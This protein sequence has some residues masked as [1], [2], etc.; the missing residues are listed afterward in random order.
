MILEERNAVDL[1]RLVMR[2][3]VLPVLLPGVVCRSPYDL[4]V[5]GIFVRRDEELAIVER[6]DIL[7][8][9]PSRCDNFPSAG[10]I[11][12]RQITDLVH[13]RGPGIYEE[14]LL[15]AGAT[16]ARSEEYVFL[17]IH[18]LVGRG[19]S[20]RMT[21]DLV[22]ALR[23]RIFLGIE[24]EFPVRGPLDRR[25]PLDLVREKLPR[26]QVFDLESVLPITVRIGRECEKVSVIAWLKSSDSEILLGHF[27]YQEAPQSELESIT[28]DGRIKLRK[29]AAKKYKEMVAAARAKG[30]RLVPISGFRSVAEQKHLFF[31]VKAER[32]QDARE[33][34]EVSAP[35]GHSEHHTGYAFDIGDGNVPATNLRQ[36]FEKTAAF[37]WLKENAPRYGFELSFP[38][39]NP[40]GVMYEPWHWRYVG[41]Q[42]SLETFYKG[43]N[44]KPKPKQE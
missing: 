38:Q 35:P 41:D 27:A 14:H 33:R 11:V 36:T 8:A 24:E 26:L 42:K 16:D 19:R 44:L 30:V 31:D 22:I 23:D 7:V 9:F 39:D 4:K 25:D 17:L 34:A 15:V 28:T 13:R 2:N 20:N 40:Q 1:Y 3:V 10:R 5:L 32:G 43:R 21:K 29:A 6:C 12:S 18:K 37:K